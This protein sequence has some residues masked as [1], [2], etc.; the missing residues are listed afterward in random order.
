MP[1]SFAEPRRLSSALTFT[2]KFIF[3]VVWVGGFAAATVRFF[4][5]PGA[6]S[7]WT[8]WIFLLVTLGGAAFLSRA[9]GRLKRVR[10]NAIALY[11][12]NY[13]SEIVVPL[14]E[15]AEVTEDYFASGHPVTIRFHRPTDFGSRITFIPRAR[16]SGLQVS[17]PA[18]DELR[19]AIGQGR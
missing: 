3:P 18:F 19:R 14:Y 5:F 11:I 16:W 10:M 1:A 6:E 12:S 7:S 15:V 4:V 8:K 9:C 2:G 13:V 17:H